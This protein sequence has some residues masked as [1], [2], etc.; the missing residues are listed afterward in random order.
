MQHVK[1]ETCSFESKTTSASVF[2]NASQKWASEE[3]KCHPN[4]YT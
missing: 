2:P 1:D 3:T 4:I